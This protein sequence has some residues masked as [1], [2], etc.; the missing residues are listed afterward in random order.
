MRIEEL[1]I[2]EKKAASL[3]AI[4]KAAAELNTTSDPLDI[5]LDSIRSVPQQMQ[6]MVD[7]IVAM[8]EEYPMPQAGW[9]AFVRDIEYTNEK[10]GLN[11][12]IRIDR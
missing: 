9:D 1:G 10:H 8:Q 2:D 11:L 3:R 6:R 5:I 7:T 12:V 4:A